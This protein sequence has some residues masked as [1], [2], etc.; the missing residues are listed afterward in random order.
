MTNVTPVKSNFKSKKIASYIDRLPPCNNACPA[1]ENIQAWLLFAKN[2]RFREAWETIVRDNPMP[3]I[4]GRVCYHYCESNCNRNKYDQSVHIHCVERFLGDMALGEGWQV[5][6]G[7]ATGKKVLIV[8]AGPAGL[9]AAHHLR[10]FGHDV[11]IYEALPVLGG[12]MRTGIPAYRLPREVLSKEAQRIIDMG[13]HLELNRRVTDVVAEKGR[14]NFDAV[15]LAIGAGKGKPLAIASDKPCQ[16]LDAIDFLKDVSLCEEIK[17]KY[18]EDAV[19]QIS[20][21]CRIDGGLKCK[22]SLVVY[23][24][25]NTAVDVARTAVRLGVKGVTILYH[26]SREKM[27]AFDFEIEEALEE[28]VKFKFLRSIQRIDGNVITLNVNELDEA[29]KPRSTGATDSITTDCLV[30]AL[31]QVPDS[32]FLRQVPG[33]EVQSNS[34]ITV[35]DKM[36]TGYAG[37]FAGGDVAPFDKSV[38]AATG[39]GKKAA[40]HINAYLNQADCTKAP[41]HEAA[42]YDY[43]HVDQMRNSNVNDAKDSKITPGMLGSSERVK[44]FAE[45]IGGFNSEEAVSEAGRCFSCGNCFECDGCYNICP[46]KAI[47]KLGAGKRYFIDINICIGCSKCFRRCPCGAI[48]MKD[49]T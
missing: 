32:D 4:H 44:S 12:M 33:I 6:V 48:I 46:V 40:R 2:G 47:S 19:H 14:G 37:I 16:I 1:G 20:S 9:A 39:H 36:M 45:V 18:A 27:P 35:D 34:S 13:V 38:T 41:K 29:G 10:L 15:F 42:S 11:T 30:L 21:I 17:S 5:S 23:G 25:G 43:L 8:G 28:G 7:N 3:A 31:S 26:R 24:G 22:G 49:R